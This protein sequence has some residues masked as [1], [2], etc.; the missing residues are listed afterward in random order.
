[1]KRKCRNGFTLIELLVVIAIIAILASLLVPAVSGALESAKTQ[2]CGSKL[3]QMHLGTRMYID[4]HQGNLLRMLWADK[5]PDDKTHYWFRELN[6]YLTDREQ[7]ECGAEMRCPTGPGYK[8]L[9][10]TINGG[11]WN[12]VDYGLHNL[13][14]WQAGTPAL[15]EMEIASPMQESLYMDFFQAGGDVF[16]TK[17][18]AKMNYFAAL[19]VRH[20]A[21]NLGG[22]NSVFVDGHVE[23]LPDPVYA[24]L[25]SSK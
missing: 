19:I 5:S 11:T 8:S 7:N 16:E 15:T 17:F 1:M 22:I 6:T 10:Q 18:N 21:G 9:G 2:M 12:G 24:D 25:T 14:N 4:D 13:R 23:L 20:P 3:H